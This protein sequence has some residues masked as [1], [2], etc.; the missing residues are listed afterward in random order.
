M[1]KNVESVSAQAMDL[2]VKCRWR[3]NIRELENVMER[4]FV[5]ADS[6]VLTKEHFP[7]LLAEDR[8]G[9]GPEGAVSVGASSMPRTLEDIEKRALTDALAYADGNVSHAARVLG[10]GRPT[11]YRKARKYGIDIRNS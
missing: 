3:G 11:F 1:V 9:T 6:S 2:L 7:T 8:A 4:A 10:I 5:L